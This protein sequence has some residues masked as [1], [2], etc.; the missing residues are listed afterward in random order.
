MSQYRHLVKK[1]NGFNIVFESPTN[2]IFLANRIIEPA[3]AK[4]NKLKEGF[5]AYAYK[6]RANAKKGVYKNPPGKYF[7][8]PPRG[9]AYWERLHEILNRE[10]V[11]EL[12]RFFMA[13]LKCVGID[14]S[15][16]MGD[17]EKSK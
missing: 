4:Y 6:D 8:G 10:V 11:V 5:R 13:I 16:S 17:F 3:P 1:L 15:W 9:M 2:N 12:E 14:K 7:F